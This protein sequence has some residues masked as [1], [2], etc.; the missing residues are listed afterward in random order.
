MTESEWLACV[1][2]QTMLEFLRAKATDRKLRLFAVA[3][4]RRFLLLTH[5]QRVSEA[6]D[7]AEQFADGLIGDMERSNARRAAQQAAQVRGVVA[8]PVA[9]KWERRAASLSYYAAARQAMEA[10]WNIPSLAVE[11]LVWREGGYNTCDWQAIKTHEGVIQSNLLRDIFGNPFRQTRLDPSWLN[12]N[13]GTVVNLAQTIYEER[14]FGL[15]PVLADALEDAGCT[16]DEL[17]A[18]C[19]R[20]GQHVRG[21]WVIDLLLGKV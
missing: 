21:C 14:A 2:P 12:W 13:E 1:D 18:H 20:P 19:R 10:A 8:R 9:P 6:L 3:V 7:I 5:D 11:V 17:L 15:L 4:S 16:S